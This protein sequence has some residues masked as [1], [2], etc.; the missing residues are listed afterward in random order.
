MGSAPCG[1]RAVSQRRDSEVESLGWRN[2]TFT[3]EMLLELREQFLRVFI[4]HSRVNDNVI[5]LL[6][7]DRGGN[8]VLVAKLKR[9]DYTKNL[10]E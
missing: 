6:P 4:A 3:Y 8:L 2:A 10:V 1:G 7:V 9:V 5:S